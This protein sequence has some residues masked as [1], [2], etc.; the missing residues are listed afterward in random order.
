MPDKAERFGPSSPSFLVSS[1]FSTSSR[2]EKHRSHWQQSIMDIDRQEGMI[3]GTLQAGE[4]SFTL[5]DGY[6]AIMGPEEVR[7]YNGIIHSNVGVFA[8]AGL[9]GEY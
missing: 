8:S 4:L 6:T 9:E 5:N 1:S 3:G 2:A 7:V